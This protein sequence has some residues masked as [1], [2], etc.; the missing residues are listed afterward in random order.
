MSYFTLST[1]LLGREQAEPT[2]CYC[3]GVCMLSPLV[4]R[5]QALVTSYRGRS[6]RCF[7]ALTP[8]RMAALSTGT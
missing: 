3:Y 8:L 1:S 6:H 5:M 4:L 2:W 7:T